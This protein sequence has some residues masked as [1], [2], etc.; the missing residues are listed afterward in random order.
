MTA[1]SDDPL[2][3]ASEK[4]AHQPSLHS[5]AEQVPVSSAQG[6]LP[7]ALSAAVPL[8]IFAIYE[9]G[10]PTAD[11]WTRLQGLGRLLAE[12]GDQLLFR[13]ALP[14]E[15]AEVFNALAE[16]L[17]LLAF[18]PGGVPFGDE[19]FDALQILSGLLGE[20]RA[21][22]YLSQIRRVGEE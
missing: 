9:R 3:H 13:S 4:E 1:F 19:R 6:L 15:T 14:G 5:P 2:N 16:A 21:R 18:L 10:G 12:R 11:D 22:S 20:E 8:R 7:T 17:A